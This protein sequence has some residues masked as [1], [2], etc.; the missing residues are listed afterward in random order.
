MDDVGK[1]CGKRKSVNIPILNGE[2]EAITDREKANMLGKAFASVH[3]GNHLDD[4]HRQRKR[5][6][7]RDNRDVSNM[8]EDDTSALDVEFTVNELKIDLQD[9]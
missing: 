7:L 3:S 6:I 9:Y 1:I 8:K 5:E 4:I 2:M